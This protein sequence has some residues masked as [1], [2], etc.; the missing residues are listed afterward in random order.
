[1]IESLTKPSASDLVA[2]FESRI[3]GPLE[4]VLGERLLAVSYWILGYDADLF[5]VEQPNA[6]GILLVGLRFES[7]TLE[8]SWGFE[9]S[10][11]G[12]LAYHVQVLPAGQT[13]SFEAVSAGN[14]CE[15]KDI[16]AAPWDNAVGK[17]LTGA[18]VIGLQGS[19]Q[20]VRFSFSGTDVVIA[21]GYAGDDLLVG[22]GDDVLVFSG[23]EWKS[24]KSSYGLEWESLWIT[25]MASNNG[26]RMSKTN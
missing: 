25:S 17:R 12:D 14:F 22:D 21:I 24:Q 26:T 2:A 7:F 13:L 3:A 15:I 5:A 6:S 9:K 20:A 16:D 11:R 19:P 23:R 8:V 18:E 1:M 4:S 10:L